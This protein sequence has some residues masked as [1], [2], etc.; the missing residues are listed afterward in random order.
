MVATEKFWYLWVHYFFATKEYLV[1]L[2]CL[3]VRGA[4]LVLCIELGMR[5][6]VNLMACTASDIP[7]LQRQ[8]HSF[9][10]TLVFMTL[11]LINLMTKNVCFKHMVS[12]CLS[13]KLGKTCQKPGDKTLT[14]YYKK[15]IN[16]T[17]IPLG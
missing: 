9:S 17:T 8:G 4:P 16:H 10:V 2:S 5:N 13:L 14:K 6:A 12:M 7:P 11:A 3:Q 15:Q 1:I